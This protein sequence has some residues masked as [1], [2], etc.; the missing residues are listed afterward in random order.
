MR[1]QFSL[2]DQDVKFLEDYGL[3]WEAVVDGSLWVLI[4]NFPLPEGYNCDNVTAAIRM[5]RGYPNTPLDMVY[6]HP[7]LK[8]LDAVTIGAASVIQPI[9]GKGFQRWSRHRSASNPWVLGQDDL[10]SHITL[11]EDWL[12]R[13]FKK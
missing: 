7:V 4:H 2:P 12:S 6:F 8:R 5:E 1:R 13:E 10:F 3:P 9:D 11:I